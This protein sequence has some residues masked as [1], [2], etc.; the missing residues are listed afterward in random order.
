MPGAHRER[1]LGAAAA[2]RLRRG[3]GRAVPDA[4]A[5]GLRPTTTSGRSSAR[6]SAGSRT[7]GASRTPGSG[8]CAGRRGTSRTR[9][10]WPGSRSTAASAS[11]EE[12]GRDGP[13]ERWRAIRDEIHAEVLAPRLERGARCLRPVVRLGGARRERARDPARRVP[14]ARR[15]ARRV[16]R[17][18]DPPRPHARRARAPVPNR[19]GRRRRRAPA[20]RGRL[21]RLLVLARR[22]A[23]A[24]G[25]AARRRGSC[26]SGCSRCGTTSGCSRRS[27]SRARGGQLG[28][29]PQ[30]FTHLALVEAALALRRACDARGRLTA[31]HGPAG[32]CGRCA[33]QRRIARCRAAGRT[34]R[35]GARRGV[36]RQLARREGAVRRRDRGQARTARRGLGGGGRE[37]GRR[38]RVAARLPRRRRARRAAGP[39]IRRARVRPSPGRDGTPSTGAA[40]AVSRTTLWMPP[41]VTSDEVAL[42]REALGSRSTDDDAARRRAAAFLAR[43]GFSSAAAWQAVRAR[44]RRVRECAASECGR[45]SLRRRSV[46]FGP[47]ET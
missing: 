6:C 43:R 33:A 34:A 18:G 27:T 20:G 25:A 46:V 44:S 11:C 22:G 7:A 13:V 40:G 36:R 12:F 23:R 4:P 26:S 35:R 14:A 31:G 32:P 9:R 17:R 19:R 8:R 2:R 30:A 21:P 38:R 1:R 16:D 45:V 37:R 15:P 24:P 3:D 29:F 47:G 39:R 41:T 10:S 42:A 5:R 28:N